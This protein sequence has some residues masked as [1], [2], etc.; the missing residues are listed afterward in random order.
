MDMNV[1]KNGEASSFITTGHSST[2]TC[3]IG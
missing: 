3:I 2:S 1:D